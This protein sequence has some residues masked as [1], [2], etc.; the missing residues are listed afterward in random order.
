MENLYN[1]IHRRNNNL[2][3]IN[4][5]WM[6]FTVNSVMII[7]K[8]RGDKSPKWTFTGIIAMAKS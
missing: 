4:N 3:I 5:F 7:Q 6:K 8:G 1:V 2:H